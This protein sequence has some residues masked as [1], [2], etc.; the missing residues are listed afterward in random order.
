M[1][2]AKSLAENEENTDLLHKLFHA[3]LAFVVV[4]LASANVVWSQTPPS[5]PATGPG[6]SQAQFSTIQQSV[7]GQA[8]QQFWIFW[9]EGLPGP[10]PV[11]VFMHGFGAVLPGPYQEWINHIAR[12]GNIVIYPRYQDDGRDV[13]ANYTPNAIGAIKSALTI[14]GAAAD[15]TKVAFV[16][17]SLGGVLNFNIAAR[18]AV[19]GI[20]A[21]K[22][23][24][25]AHPGDTIFADLNSYSQISYDTVVLMLVGDADN[26]V[27]D[28][29]AKNILAALP[30]IRAKNFITVRSDNHGSPALVADHLAPNAPPVDALDYF[31]YWKLSDALIDFVFFGTEADYATGGGNNQIFMGR[32]SDGITVRPLLLRPSLSIP[33]V[34]NGAS[35][36]PGA[37]APGEIIVLF[38]SGLGPDIPQLLQLDSTG[39]V[40]KNVA[41][42]Q[43]LIGGI[44]SPVLYTWMNRVS[45]V[46]PYAVAGQTTVPLQVQ[47]GSYTSETVTVDVRESAVG[48][49]SAN[50]GG[51]GQGAILNQNFS[52]NSPANPA[53]KD[54]FV[55][56]FATGEGLTD[57][58]VPDGTV[59]NAAPSRP[60]LPVSVTIGGVGAEIRYAGAAPGFVAGT[61]QVV[62]RV[63]TALSSGIH[64][65][66]VTVGNSQ[67]QSG[68]TLAVK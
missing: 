3:V 13:P 31:A 16:G 2:R 8:G 35:L 42:M 7:Y 22:A 65:V 62:V 17:H 49:F 66:S 30:Y 34:L 47:Y 9:P 19:E 4:A 58:A 56:I 33:D 5:Q 26:L 27:G 11:V 6:G 39:R 60:R 44:P 18:A 67:S 51:S 64:P 53:S 20:P 36:Y 25:S 1:G 63:P 41:G 48:V 45:V 32:W 28:T 43:V 40:G 24:L 21:P 12:R 15:L 38:G 23:I 57:S 10:A 59:T 14:L 52:A 46:V 68:I 29:T 61:F 55:I 37:I 54:S 50:P